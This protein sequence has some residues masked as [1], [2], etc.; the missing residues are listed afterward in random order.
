[1]G[2]C[3][4][5]SRC[6]CKEDWTG[7]NC[8]QPTYCNDFPDWESGEWISILT[9]PHPSLFLIVFFAVLGAVLLLVVYQVKYQR[10][11]RGAAAPAE[12]TLGKIVGTIGSSI[13]GTGGSGYQPVASGETAQAQAANKGDA[14]SRSNGGPSW[15]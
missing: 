2:R 12:S 7:P 5:F 13:L 10:D 9:Y 15:L 6:T 8:L 11:Q 4:F 14:S 1:M 3:N